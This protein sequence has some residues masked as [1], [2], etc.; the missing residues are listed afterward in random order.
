[1]TQGSKV[2]V[3]LGRED[4]SKV[5]SVFY[6][7]C[8]S[9]HHIQSMSS[10]KG[11]KQV[12]KIGHLLTPNDKL[13]KSY[14]EQVLSRFQLDGTKE[15]LKTFLGQN[16]RGRKH[17]MD[18]RDYEKKNLCRWGRI[19]RGKVGMFSFHRSCQKFFRMVVPLYAHIRRC[20]RNPV[21]H[22]LS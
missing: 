3:E 10:Y 16:L 17:G 9:A 22:I 7:V 8:C 20:M 13:P 19:Y 21:T 5:V 2:G 6:C 15:S 12:L 14:A 18:P 4:Q 11:I 1:M